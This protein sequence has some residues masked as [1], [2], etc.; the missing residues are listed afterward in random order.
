MSVENENFDALGYYEALELDSDASANDIKSNYRN[1]AKIWHPDQNTSEDALERFQQI[2]VAYDILK[3]DRKKLIYDLLSQVYTKDSF[4]DMFS[5]KSYKDLDGNEDPFVRGVRLKKVIGKFMKYTSSEDLD[6]CS[7]NEAKKLVLKT[8]FS[9]WLLGW[10]SLKSFGL[11]IKAILGNIRN[12]DKN[13][14]DNLR[15]LIHNSIAYWGEKKNDKALFSLVQAG[16][17]ANIGQ[18]AL[19]HKLGAMIGGKVPNKISP[20]NYG[21]LKLLQLIFPLVILVLAALPF[22]RNI[23]SFDDFQMYV[24]KDKE[25]NYYQE[26]KFS[27]TGGR[28]FDDVLV[29]KVVDIPV[30]TKDPD[31]LFYVASKTNVMHAPGDDFDLLTVIEAKT[32]VR[33]TGYTPDNVWFRI[34]LDGG[35]MGFVR[36]NVLRRGIGEEI[37]ANSKIYEKP[38]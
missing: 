25:M 37:P 29:S 33:V 6:V 22:T 21:Y 14:K 5:L 7:F 11:N 16:D 38:F 9:N 23:A 18:K 10:W 20:W 1:I 28:T 12:I 19:L 30:D 4:P 17:Y 15:L 34:M 8:S 13:K 32:T 2:S 36:K 3:D 24:S 31:L 26:V 35:E 27:R